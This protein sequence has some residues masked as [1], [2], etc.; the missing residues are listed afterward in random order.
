[1]KAIFL[2]LIICSVANAQY[3]YKGVDLTNY[4][5]QAD[6]IDCTI[7]GKQ[8]YGKY[9]VDFYTKV[10]IFP[11]IKMISFVAP[12]TS[13]RI[14]QIYSEL[15]ELFQRGADKLSETGGQWVID[16]TTISIIYLSGTVQVVSTYD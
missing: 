13:N 5:K 2:F 4:E 3:I 10:V 9:D 12:K 7:D 8:S 14:G 16:R 6:F 11:D 15:K 1:M